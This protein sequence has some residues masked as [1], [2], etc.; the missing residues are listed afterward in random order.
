MSSYFHLRAVATGLLHV[1]LKIAPPDAAEWGHAMLGELH[2][3]EGDWAAL[4][5]ALGSAS[6]LAKHA[7][8]SL[9]IPAPSNQ[10]VSEGRFFDRETPMKKSTLI[11]AA[12][13]TVVSGG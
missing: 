9:L 5:W 8:L 12:A 4:A 3:V 1:G 13:C 7:L 6:V 10:I 2:H 11:V